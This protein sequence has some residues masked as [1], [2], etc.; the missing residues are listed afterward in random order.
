[1]VVDGFP[2][3]E[4]FED[5]SVYSHKTHTK[6]KPLINTNGYLKYHL[7]NNG[8]MTNKY[9]HILVAEHFLFRENTEESE[10]DHIDR[11]K[12][13]NHVSNL[14][15]VTPKKNASHMAGSARYINQVGLREAIPRSPEEISKVQEMFIDGT[16]VC[17]IA[18][19]L[20]IPRQ[21]VSRYVKLI[22]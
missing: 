5:G 15:Y 16:K 18:R 13:N 20:K 8:K 6:L 11:D 2:N 12:N 17:E 21:S 1:M 22:A 10:I 7:Y 9:V 4:I 3:Y 19:L 14:R